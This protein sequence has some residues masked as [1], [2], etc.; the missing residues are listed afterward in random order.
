MV[1]AFFYVFFLVGC[2]VSATSVVNSL[3][4]TALKCVVDTTG[5]NHFMIGAQ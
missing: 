2:E 4:R 1:S 5:L 3:G